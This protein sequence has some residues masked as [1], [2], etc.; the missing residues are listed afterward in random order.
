VAAQ[1]LIQF[2][3]PSALGRLEICM[4]G[5]QMGRAPATD[6]GAHS[7]PAAYCCRLHAHTMSL[8]WLRD[9]SRYNRADNAAVVVCGLAHDV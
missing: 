7:L 4:V 6:E 2:G 9:A 8:T 1:R 3:K 5:S